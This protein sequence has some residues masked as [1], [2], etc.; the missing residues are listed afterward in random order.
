M[1]GVGGVLLT[2]TTAT[3]DLDAAF[4]AAL[5][6]WRRPFARHDPGK[7]MLDLAISRAMGGD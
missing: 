6:P 5:A 3:V 4:R 7:I 2:H 1:S